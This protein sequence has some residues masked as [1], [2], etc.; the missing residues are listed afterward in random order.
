MYPL[1]SDIKFDHLTKV[2]S[3]RF[4]HCQGSFNLYSVNFLFLESF[5]QLLYHALMVLRES[6]FLFNSGLKM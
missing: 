6:I 4:L 3:N 5:H 2:V 1:I